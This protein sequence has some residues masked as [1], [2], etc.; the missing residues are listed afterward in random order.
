MKVGE[1]V[2]SVA[3]GRG[4]T[5]TVQ[6]SSDAAPAPAQARRTKSPVRVPTPTDK[7]DHNGWRDDD[8]TTVAV[9][10]ADLTEAVVP[11]STP[12]DR[13]SLRL[14]KL[15][16]D[17][18]ANIALAREL[19]WTGI[20]QKFRATLWLM[21]MVCPASRAGPIPETPLTVA[22]RESFQR[23]APDESSR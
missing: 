13:K 22:A 2:W 20:P 14:R 3:Y 1:R 17:D 23:I 12:E 9:V 19:C 6:S 5:R 21:L 11:D 16:D 8:D 7:P 4:V 10:T 15:L 18:D